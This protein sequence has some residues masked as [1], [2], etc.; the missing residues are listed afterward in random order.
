M[1]IENLTF[2]ETNNLILYSKNL[3]L[4]TFQRKDNFD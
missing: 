1:Y 4:Y 2:A 3:D